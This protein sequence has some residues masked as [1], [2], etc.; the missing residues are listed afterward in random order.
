M[1]LE[2]LPLQQQQDYR[3]EEVQLIQRVKAKS[4]V[5]GNSRAEVAFENKYREQHNPTIGARRG[6][7]ERG[8]LVPPP[9]T[10]L[11]CP[12]IVWF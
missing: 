12:K 9:L 7:G 10:D 11:G 4:R 5:R 3:R 6:E 8:A 2:E 1:T